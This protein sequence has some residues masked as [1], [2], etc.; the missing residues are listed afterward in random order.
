MAVAAL[1]PN[2]SIAVSTMLSGSDIS[3]KSSRI[4]AFSLSLGARMLPLFE[5]C[6]K[7]TR[8]LGPAIWVRIGLAGVGRFDRPA[9]V[10]YGPGGAVSS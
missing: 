1:L 5:R 4:I 3:V 2:R 10:D 6:G 7:D 8:S 9:L